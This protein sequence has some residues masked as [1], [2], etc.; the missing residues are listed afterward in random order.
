MFGWFKNKIDK[1]INSYLENVPNDEVFEL[2]LEDG[3]M[4]LDTFK[5]EGE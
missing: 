3:L 4:C 5:E 1:K 2:E